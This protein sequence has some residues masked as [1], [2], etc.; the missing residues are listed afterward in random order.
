MSRRGLCR[1]LS[2]LASSLFALDYARRT[3]SHKESGSLILGTYKI[4]NS[5]QRASTFLSTGRN[6]SCL[7]SKVRGEFPAIANNPDNHVLCDAPTGTQAHCTA[8]AAISDYLS[9]VNAN[10]GGRNPGGLRAVDT[11]RRAREVAAAFMNCKEQEVCPVPHSTY[12]SFSTSR[13][14]KT[15]KREHD[16]RC[17]SAPT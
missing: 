16:L 2:E 4:H 8:I 13:V 14:K 11:A 15:N 9:N 17:S 5:C 3:R 1:Q 7:G 10:L 12:T 6:M